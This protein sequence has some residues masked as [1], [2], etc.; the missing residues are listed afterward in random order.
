MPVTDLTQKQL[1]FLALAF[2]NMPRT[3]SVM[4]SQT[5]GV[6]L[7]VE[8]LL[9]PLLQNL[10]NWQ[11]AIDAFGKPMTT[12]SAKRF[13]I[14]SINSH[15]KAK[16]DL[17]SEEQRLLVEKKW[18][19]AAREKALA[20]NKKVL[21]MDKKLLA[22]Q[23]QKVVEGKEKLAAEERKATREHEIDIVIDDDTDDGLF[24]PL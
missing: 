3:N 11:G 15:H 10:V 1:E 24:V 6:A 22:E 14:K 4:V 20:L 17:L 19:L 18:K 8:C 16:D 21:A 13:V 23:E 2:L 12:D 9:T 5:L 7:C